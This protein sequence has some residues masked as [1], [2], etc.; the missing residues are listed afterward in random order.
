M[1]PTTAAI[2]LAAL[3]L[4]AVAGADERMEHSERAARTPMPV[5]RTG[6]PGKSAFLETDKLFLWRVHWINHNEVQAGE[7]AKTRGQLDGVS[8]FGRTLAED[9]RKVENQLLTLAKKKNL[10][11]ELSNHEYQR[12]RDELSRQMT[13][14]M[15]LAHANGAAFDREFLNH[16]A[17]G[18]KEA[19]DLL[20]SFREKTHDEEIRFFIDETLPVFQEHQRT[21]NKL[22][23]KL[24]NERQDVKGLD[25]GDVEEKLK[26]VKGGTPKTRKQKDLP[27]EG[28]D[29][30][31]D[32]E[33]DIEQRIEPPADSGS[34]PDLDPF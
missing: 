10:A 16:M 1:R 19:I 23:D 31:E 29:Q 14:Q 11:M 34:T 4:A 20:K 8:S 21:A 15:D 30:Q 7:L 27:E 33:T 18:H 26:G 17:Q 24:G 28:S 13:I 5:D 2:S 9:H 25:D 32:L 22:L 12:V 6:E 3:L